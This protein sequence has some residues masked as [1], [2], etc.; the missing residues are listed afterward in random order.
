ME[1]LLMLAQATVSQPP[2]LQPQT[3][4]DG[5]GLPFHLHGGIGQLTGLLVGKLHF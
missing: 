1:Y 4:A 2:S 5:F 3:L